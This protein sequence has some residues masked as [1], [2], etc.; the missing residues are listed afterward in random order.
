M[1]EIELSRY[2]REKGFYIEEVKKWRSS[3][4]DANYSE[5]IDNK[6]LMQEIQEE[7]INREV[8]HADELCGVKLFML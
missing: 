3:C 6:E 8:I 4:I 7:L 2:C 1:S 5:T